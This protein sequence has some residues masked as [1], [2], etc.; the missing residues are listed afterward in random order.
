MQIVIIVLAFEN[1]VLIFKNHAK[2][3]TDGE[4]VNIQKFPLEIE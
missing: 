3:S 1:L 4:S 2:D